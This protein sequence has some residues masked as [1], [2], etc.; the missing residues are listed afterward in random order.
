MAGANPNAIRLSAEILALREFSDE[1]AR[2]SPEITP[3]M[4]DLEAL[5]LVSER[6]SDLLTWLE[7]KRQ[8]AEAQIQAMTATLHGGQTN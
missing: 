7:A 8:L 1:I 3:A 2:L 6:W 5:R 4:T